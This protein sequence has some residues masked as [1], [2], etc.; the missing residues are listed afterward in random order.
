MSIVLS[1]HPMVV[2]ISEQILA[3]HLGNY[4]ITNKQ[5]AERQ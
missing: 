1:N 4:A 5:V 3:G 2:K